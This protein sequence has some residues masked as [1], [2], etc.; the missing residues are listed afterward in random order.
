MRTS[1][2]AA[3]AVSVSV[4]AVRIGTGDADVAGSCTPGYSPCLPPAEDYDCAGG[5]GN[6]PKYTPPPPPPDVVG[7]GATT[8]EITRWIS[9]RLSTRA[10]GDAH[11][12]LR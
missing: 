4:K 3:D 5:S 1:D 6:G 11:A 12:G 10:A 8:F 9:L 2:L 7:A